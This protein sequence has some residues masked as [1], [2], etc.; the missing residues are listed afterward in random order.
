LGDKEATAFRALAARGIYLG[1][2]RSDMCFAAKELSRKI[3][4]P[5][6][7]DWVGMKRLARYLLDK[8]RC[9]VKYSYQEWVN[10][11]NVWV[12][13]DWAGCHETR[14]STSGGVIMHGRHIVKHWS[15]TQ[16]VIALS[17]G[18][19]EYY[20][21][22][23]GA[24]QGLGVKGLMHDMG[25]SVKI[26]VK[27]DASAAKGI[28]S[29]R[30]LGKIKHIELSQLWVQEKMVRREIDIRKVGTHENLADALT[31]HVGREIVER[32]CSG[33]DCEI[34]NDRHKEMPVLGA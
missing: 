25:E 26:T 16:N 30:G 11:I 1:H 6:V 9:V 13:S 21:I 4:S 5:R 20:A 19:A 3:S 24:S 23:K 29:R 2:D 28:A 7:C 18:E 34:R 31:K 8:S 17:S 33:V 27:T 10:E 14:K 22:V 32:H 12:D 15:S